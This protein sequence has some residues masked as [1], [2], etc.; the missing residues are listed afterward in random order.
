MAANPLRERPA[1]QLMLALYRSGRQAEALEAYSRT[2]QR[3][4]DELG[5][6]P[7]PE[8]QR[9]ERAILNQDPSLDLAASERPAPA[10]PPAH[11]GSTVDAAGQ[12]QDGH[13]ALRGLRAH[14]DAR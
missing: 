7:S 9:L 6:D 1:G 3:L 13:R 5:I 14:A 2:R 11:G 8:L 4:V 12:P 10:A